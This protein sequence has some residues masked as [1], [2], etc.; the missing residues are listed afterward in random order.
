MTSIS[1]AI[2]NPFVNA[3]L[4]SGCPVDGCGKENPAPPVCHGNVTSAHERLCR[5]LRYVTSPAVMEPY[6][7][8]SCL[9]ALHNDTLTSVA[10]FFF[11]PGSNGPQLFTIEQWGTP[12]KLPRAHTWYVTTQRQT[13]LGVCRHASS[14][15]RPLTR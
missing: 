13:G 10:S 3:H 8:D 7:T 12:D 5:A 9:C 4:S 11:V 6:S 1:T 15:V 14:C 2:I